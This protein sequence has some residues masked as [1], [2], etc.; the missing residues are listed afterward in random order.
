MWLLITKIAHC[1]AFSKT[2]SVLPSSVRLSES[3]SFPQENLTWSIYCNIFILQYVFS[4]KHIINYGDKMNVVLRKTSQWSHM[5]C[6]YRS[7]I[8]YKIAQTVIKLVKT[9]NSVIK[10]QRSR[11]KLNIILSL[12]NEWAKVW[13]SSERSW[14]NTLMTQRTD[15]KSLLRHHYWRPYIHKQQNQ[16][17]C[18]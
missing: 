1:L 5:C 2:V 16:D 7:E 11:H 15:S 17:I 13:L 4:L 10:S 18:T 6:A 14:L 3:L 12:Y 8:N 9:P